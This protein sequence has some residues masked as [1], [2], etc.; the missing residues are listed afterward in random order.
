MF[1]ST[2]QSVL[3]FAVAV[4]VFAGT[5]GP[6]FSQ[7]RLKPETLAGF[8]DFI[9]RAEESMSKRQSDGAVFLWLAEDPSRLEHAEAGDLIIERLD[10]DADLDSGMIHNWIGGMFVPG[11]SID[12]I[13]AVFLDYEKYPDMYPGVVESRLLESDGNSNT[14]YQ[15]LRRDDLVLDTWH[16]AGYR[17]LD[18]GRAET[19]S[20]STEVREVLK[21]GEADEQLLPDGEGHGYMWRIHVYWR[22]EQREDGVFA[23]CHSISMSR[24]IPFLLRW[25][26]G[27]FA[28]RIPRQGLERSLEATRIR[29]RKVAEASDSLATPLVN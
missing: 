18:E 8:N 21:P 3:K 16:D 19:W 14:L 22:L 5:T 27:P 17:I 11:V 25:I 9:E 12:D 2:T 10:D 6:A 20:R 15:R 28:R 24:E 1:R 29:A 4:A 26:V 23:E 13:L 7:Q